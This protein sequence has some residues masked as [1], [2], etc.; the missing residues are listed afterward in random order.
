MREIKFRVW[1]HNKNEWE[2]DRVFL[3]QEGNMLQCK[4]FGSPTPIGHDTHTIEQFTGLLDKNGKEVF[5]GDV[6]AF[7]G[8]TSEV[9]WKSGNARFEAH[10]N[11][12]HILR[13]HKFK[14]AEVIGNK[15]QHP[16]LLK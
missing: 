4:P 5:E 3:A 10:E 8:W 15:H 13:A 7:D 11:G 2:A 6:I 1:C 9:K 16:E 14:L 12:P